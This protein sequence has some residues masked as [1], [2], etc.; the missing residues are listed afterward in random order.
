MVAGRP[1]LGNRVE[2]PGSGCPGSPGSGIFM[3]SD[4]MYFVFAMFRHSP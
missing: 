2:G 1:W 4:C 3:N